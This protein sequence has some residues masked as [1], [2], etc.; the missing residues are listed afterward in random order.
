MK[1]AGCNSY[2]NCQQLGIV[3][4]YRLV[5][6]NY[7]VVSF[8]A[9]SEADNAPCNGNR[10]IWMI[11]L[12]WVICSCENQNSK[13]QLPK[14]LIVCSEIV[15][16]CYLVCTLNNF[17]LWGLWWLPPAPWGD[18]PV[19]TELSLGARLFLPAFHPHFPFIQHNVPP[20]NSSTAPLCPRAAVARW[21]VCRSLP[22]L[23]G[24]VGH[25]CVQRE[26]C[27]FIV[28]AGRCVFMCPILEID[29]LF[30]LK[31]SPSLK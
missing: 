20:A 5:I 9:I 25:C 1:W 27:I 22:R 24:L 15:Q 13:A 2:S 10:A 3:F 28:R 29:E 26:G 4:P 21:V 17:V 19:N 16:G 7:S 30:W 18:L 14:H 23:K 8:L 6:W 11:S 12:D 31:S